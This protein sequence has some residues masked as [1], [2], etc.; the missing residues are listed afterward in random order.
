MKKYLSPLSYWLLPC[1]FLV[2]SSLTSGSEE[3]TE[4][5]TEIK[6]PQA[7][8]MGTITVVAATNRKNSLSAQVAD[9]YAKRL[10]E[11]GCNS[12]VLKLTALPADFTVSALYENKGQH[13]EFHKLQEMMTAA[14]KYVFIVPEYNGSFPGVFKAFIDGLKFPDTFSGKRCAMV[15]VSKG[16]Q[17]SVLALSHL[18]D[19]FHH[20]KMNVYPLKLKLAN[21]RDSQLTTVL[22]NAQYV[23][24]LE[25]QVTGIIQY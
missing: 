3:K 15:G 23:S 7:P 10:Q 1:L 8:N 21:I 24:L 6:N 9:Y 12:Q 13:P 22:A 17:G 4:Q 14:Q 25:E 20:L 18:T 5:P 16:I 2:F 11:H 19:I